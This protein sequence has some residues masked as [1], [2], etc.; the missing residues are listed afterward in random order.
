MTENDT[1]VLPVVEGPAQPPRP[2]EGEPIRAIVQEDPLPQGEE[3]Y[4]CC[5]F[6]LSL[7]EGYLE[8]KQYCRLRIAKSLFM[9]IIHKFLTTIKS[10]LPAA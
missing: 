10:N 9:R 1:G 8:L 2:I 5:K 3:T 4:R 6:M 7:I